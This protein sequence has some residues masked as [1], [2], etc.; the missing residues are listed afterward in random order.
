MPKLWAIFGRNSFAYENLNILASFSRLLQRQLSAEAPGSC[1]ADPF[2]SPALVLEFHLVAFH[3]LSVT[4]ITRQN[5]A[6][7][8]INELYFM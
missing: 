8:L 7:G 6:S 2:H 1:P 5:Y 4:K 3:S